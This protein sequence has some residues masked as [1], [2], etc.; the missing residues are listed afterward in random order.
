MHVHLSANASF[1]RKSVVCLLARLARRPY[2]L[3][4]HSGFFPDFYE[5]Q[6]GPLARRLIRQTF[7]KAAL[8]IALSEQ[9]RSWLLK[10]SAASRIE[11]LPNA[12]SLPDLSSVR[13][14]EASSPTLLFLGD[15][16]ASKGI[17]DLAHA[18]ARVS[19]QFP[20]LRLVCGGLGA[21]DEL[22]RL[23]ERLG[24]AERVHCPGW[25]GADRKLEELAAAQA[26]V[27][28]SHAEALP[29]A[30][31]EAMSWQLPVIA[32]PVG[33][34][35]QVIQHEANG[36]LVSPGDIEGTAAAIARLMREP[37]LAHRLGAAA[38]RTVEQSFSLDTS[39]ERL[40]Q[41]YRSFGIEPRDA[42]GSTASPT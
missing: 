9:W 30:L 26:F 27:L 8:L 13:R 23:C 18:F 29:M 12:V 21:V 3:H 35:P 37:A 17:F 40:L 15:I 39:V 20:R 34:I 31:L 4:V 36:L 2:L 1:W 7:D 10:I 28:P 38:R 22:R 6:S 25:L 42:P 33:G 5:R 16:N 41:I 24:I 11:V 32:T 19:A 14:S